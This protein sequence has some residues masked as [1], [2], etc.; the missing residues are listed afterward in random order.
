[1][2]SD[3]RNTFAPEF[4]DRLDEM[5][6]FHPLDRETL[7]AITR[8]LLAETQE[9]LDKLGVAMEV[10]PEAVAL[11]AGQGSGKKQGARPLRRA[12]ANLVE[13]PAADLLLA[14]TVKKGGTLKVAVRE[15]RVRV[16]SE[17]R[18]TVL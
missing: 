14:G 12:I 1:M 11:L 13:D 7:E 17:D 16:E 8:Q 4:L 6:V 10:E 9:R 3:A 15:G 5:L 18:S 2:L